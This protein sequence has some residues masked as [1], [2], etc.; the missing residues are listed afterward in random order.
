M[1][2]AAF[3]AQ[4]DSL[5]AFDTSVSRL[6][7][8]VNDDNA[9]A[10]HIEAAI[11][12]EPALTANLL[13]VANS[14][15]MGA[16]KSVGTVKEAVIRVGAR[17]VWEVAVAG[18]YVKRI[19]QNLVAYNMRASE[20]WQH[21]VATAVIAQRV[22]RITRKG[23]PE[24]A[25]TAGLLHDVGKL[26][27]QSALDRKADGLPKIDRGALTGVSIERHLLGTDH[28][29][30]GEIVAQRWSLPNEL[31]LALGYHE[32]PSQ[33]PD[34]EPT[35]LVYIVHVANQ[36]AHAMT[37]GGVIKEPTG[38]LEPLMDTAVLDSLAIGH[39]IMQKLAEQSIKEIQSMG[40][41][42]GP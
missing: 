14:A 32:W 34:G 12:S 33:V 27:I 16:A 4:V 31:S 28:G 5:P 1:T 26:V 13:R 41:A 29:A 20:F 35:N 36:I 17:R 9:T 40:S 42:F 11:R 22:C 8:L 21:S 30:I 15:A 39:P 19:P 25:F 7:A 18:A 23:D 38:N 24:T 3:L 37:I 2:A 10:A 6:S